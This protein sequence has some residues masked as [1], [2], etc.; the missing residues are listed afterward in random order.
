MADT[1][2]EPEVSASPVLNPLRSPAELKISTPLLVNVTLLLYLSRPCHCYFVL[3]FLFN[4]SHSLEVKAFAS[5]LTSQ[6]RSGLRV[7]PEE[8]PSHGELGPG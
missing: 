7:I 3:L 5:H 4:L 2:F 6:L 1:G 8:L